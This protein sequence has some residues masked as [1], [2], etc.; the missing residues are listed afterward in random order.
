MAKL[1]PWIVRHC[2]DCVF[3][4]V[5]KLDSEP[6]YSCN[7]DDKWEPKKSK[8]R[9]EVAALRRQLEERGVGPD[10]CEWHPGDIRGTG[11]RGWK[12]SCGESMYP[13]HRWRISEDGLNFCPNCGKRAV[14]VTDDE[15]AARDAL[16]SGEAG[17][18][19]GSSNA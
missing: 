4:D 13:K 11:V 6:C 5:N 18:K 2:E 8:L 14:Q 3:C 1:K 15:W 9:S 16:R 7:D 12:T 17:T 10:E 19:G